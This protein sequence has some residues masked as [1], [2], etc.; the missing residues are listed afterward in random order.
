M[1]DKKILRDIFYNL[2]DHVTKILEKYFY[3]SS[4]I[5]VLTAGEQQA[6]RVTLSRCHPPPGLICQPFL[7][8]F[9]MNRNH[10]SVCFSAFGSRS[11]IWA[12]WL[13]SVILI[14]ANT[15]SVEA[16]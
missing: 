14:G 11:I 10:M 15:S 4:L 7:C 9:Y 12:I 3:L 16:D 13:A 1:P 6:K 8:S 2:Q 5:D